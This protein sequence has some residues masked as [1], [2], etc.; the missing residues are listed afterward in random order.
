MFDS[1]KEVENKDN[2][3]KHQFWQNHDAAWS[4]AVSGSLSIAAARG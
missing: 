2:Q 4:K 1:S 3:D